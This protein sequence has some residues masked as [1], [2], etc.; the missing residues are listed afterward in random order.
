MK[1]LRKGLSR[2]RDVVLPPLCLSCGDV[3]GDDGA[4]CPACWSDLSFISRPFCD[5]CGLPFESEAKAGADDDGGLLCLACSRKM[6]PFSKARSVLR[7]DGACRH[8]VHR[9]KYGDA[10]H[11]APHLGAFM[12]RAASDLPLAGAVVVPVPLHRW[13]MV[14][15]MYNQAALLGDVFARK[16]GLE[17]VPD[18]L[19]RHRATRTQVGL[20]RQERQN[21]LKG[22]FCIHP[23]RRSVLAGKTVVLVDDVMTTG[24]TMEECA[25]V[26]L[27]AGAARVFVVTLARACGDDHPVA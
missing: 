26:L 15:R 22:A 6:P 14:L 5:A 7:Y 11:A 4:I 3:L 10:T 13:R 20:S 25:R 17:M 24:T 16:T 12:A 2:L 1:R 19:V 21:N 8:L 23:R 18:L 9:F 27:S